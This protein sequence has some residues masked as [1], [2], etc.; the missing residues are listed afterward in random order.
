MGSRLKRRGE[1]GFSNELRSIPLLRRGVGVKVE[2][3]KLSYGFGVA[4]YD[5]E[6]LFLLAL[7]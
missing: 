1:V 3:N 6:G 5:D 2:K 4:G 7:Y